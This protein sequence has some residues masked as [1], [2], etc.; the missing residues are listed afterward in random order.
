M[1][2]KIL[3]A[4][5]NPGK[6]KE[7]QAILDGTVQCLS[8]EDFADIPEVLEEGSTFAENARKKAIEYAK[9]TGLRTL[10]DDSGLVVDALGGAPGVYSARY[11]GVTGSD[12]Q[13]IDQANIQKLL[14]DLEGIPLNR[15][16]ACFVCHICLADPDRVL[17]ECEGSV[18]GRIIDEPRGD[19]GFGYD[20]VFLLPEFEQTAAQ[21]SKD[22]KNIISHRGQAIA[23]L[24]PKW[25]KLLRSSR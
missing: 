22:Q 14:Q 3:I 13:M 25:Q 18:E 24:I 9:A 7:F 1:P 19:N 12:R 8:L 15:R 17:L 6:I 20:P 10:S 11:A 21:L 16:R 2:Q 5:K 4:T 23:Q